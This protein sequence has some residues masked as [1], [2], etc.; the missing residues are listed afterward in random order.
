MA[1]Y[2]Y[3]NGEFV[4]KATGEPMLTAEEKARKPEA[5]QIM[6]FK[7]YECPITGKE[8]RTLQQHNDNLKR[9]NCVDANDLPSPTGGKIRNPKFAKK[10]GLEVSEEY[11]DQPFK[12]EKHPQSEAV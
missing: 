3:R 1:T 11:K 4:D 2:V 10:H 9:H 12:R 5:P 8:I 6:G 7:A